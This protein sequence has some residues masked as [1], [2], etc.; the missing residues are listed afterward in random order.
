MSG[1]LRIDYAV[2]TE[3]GNKAE[4]AD[5]A[6]AIVPTGGALLNKG[7]AAAIADGM[8]SSE[9]GRD[10]S[11]VCVSGFLDCGTMGIAGGSLS[12]RPLF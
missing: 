4:N 11:Q 1:T 12:G 9:G 2:R 5:A 7:I 6:D 3:A 10:A 8:S